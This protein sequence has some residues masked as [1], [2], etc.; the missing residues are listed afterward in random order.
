MGWF[1]FKTRFI[2]CLFLLLLTGI[3][4][5]L[6]DSTC[7]GVKRTLQRVWTNFCWQWM[8]ATI[9]DFV[10]SCAVC[11]R[12]KTKYLHLAGLLQ[13][14]PLPSWVWFDIS[15]DF[16]EG[17]PKANGKSVLFVVVDRFS[18]L[19]HFIPLSHPYTAINVAQAFF[20]NLSLTRCSGVHC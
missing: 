14:L 16:I 4:A 8:H 13:L 10:T 18:K 2:Y 17:L 1:I 9:R 6:H 15:I 19:V 7:E 12:H 20:S 5:A 11:Q 3:V